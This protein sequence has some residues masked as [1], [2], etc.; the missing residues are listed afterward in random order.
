MLDPGRLVFID[1]TCT[2]RAMVRLRGRSLRGE[3]L[4]GY[5]PHGY[6]KTITFVA[7]LRLRRITAP[8]V[9]DGAMNGPMFLAYINQCLVP[10]LTRGD[11]VVMD[12]LPVHEVAGVQEAVE[13]AGSVLRYL[14]PY[15][16][17]LNPIEMA[18]AK[19]KVLLRKPAERA[20][21]D[22]LRRTGRIAKAFSPRECTNFLR[23]AGHVRT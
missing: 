10:T 12:N 1:E 9:L 18:F 19:L 8:F 3:R 17:D 6:R 21:P 22:L 11:I 5:A 13:A 14:P 23:H 16:L 2:S 4:V 7:D 15:S 20:I